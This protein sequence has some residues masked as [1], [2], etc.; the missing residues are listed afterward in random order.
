MIFNVFNYVKDY[1]INKIGFLNKLR[2]ENKIK[3]K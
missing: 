3:F 1:F 2:F